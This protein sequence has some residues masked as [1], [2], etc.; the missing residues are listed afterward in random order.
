[1]PD[2]VVL[3]H[4][5]EG[6][7]LLLAEI[8]HP[9]EIIQLE[10]YGVRLSI[11]GLLGAP[12]AG[13]LTSLGRVVLEVTSWGEVDLEMAWWNDPEADYELL[14]PAR[15]GLPCDG[16]PRWPCD[17]RPVYPRFSPTSL[18][19]AMVPVSTAALPFHVIAT[20][21]GG[22]GGFEFSEETE[23]MTIEEQYIWIGEYDVTV[24]VDTAGLE[25]GDYTGW[26][27]T[28]RVACSECTPVFLT[29]TGDDTPVEPESWGRLKQRFASM[30]R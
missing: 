25:P 28:T 17:A 5:P 2:A 29:V 30:A 27:T 3:L 6:W 23:W 15:A 14:T 16:C 9:L 19:F 12:Q 24:T 26:V 22:G 8:C 1:M 7:T 11:P 4:W 13:D 21:T 10:G 20:G 18:M